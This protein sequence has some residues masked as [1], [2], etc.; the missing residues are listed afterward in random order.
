MKN[1]LCPV[2]F[3]ACLM[4]AST[5]EAQQTY[6]GTGGVF[7]VGQ[8]SV[9]LG[10]T[11]LFSE[12][13][14]FRGLAL[15]QKQ[16]AASYW[17]D[18]IVPI[19]DELPTWEKFRL[20]YQFNQLKPFEFRGQLYDDQLF[21]RSHFV[22]LK[23][24]GEASPGIFVSAGGEVFFNQVL[25][26]KNPDLNGNFTNEDDV[27]PINYGSETRG[28]V[29][30]GV[31]VQD[32]LDW[33]SQLYLQSKD[34]VD[35]N[36][37]IINGRAA[38]TYPTRSKSSGMDFALLDKFDILPL[39]TFFEILHGTNKPW[40]FSQ[41]VSALIEQKLYFPEA[42]AFAQVGSRNFAGFKQN[43]FEVKGGL[44]ALETQVDAASIEEALAAAG[45]L[46]VSAMAR[47]GDGGMYAYTLAAMAFGLKVEISRQAKA[48]DGTADKLGGYA[49]GYSL[50]Y[51]A[52]DLDVSFYKN[53]LEHLDLAPAL[54]DTSF[55]KFDFGVRI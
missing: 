8:Q 34:A 50:A 49:I 16:G 35:P 31:M 46:S 15:Q 12:L 53:Y 22:S 30:A 18:G 7:A 47:M 23:A 42:H 21:I 37:A 14:M 25:S 27:R 33:R 38:L 24:R 39:G 26:Q 1:Q 6:D 28:S 5:A 48:H 13:E 54:R 9:T 29:T 36:R 45:I 11:S 51:D 20:R 3:A 44:L 10:Q 41:T 19:P 32:W 55:L 17:P 2:L 52:V 43:F 40:D 4:F